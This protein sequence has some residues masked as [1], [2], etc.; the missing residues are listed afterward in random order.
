MEYMDKSV[1]DLT[2]E[3]MKSITFQ[4]VPQFYWKYDW[5]YNSFMV[6]PVA[7]LN[8]TDNLMKMY[9]MLG[10]V[11]EWV[12]DDWSE[13]IS[14]AINGTQ[15]KPAVNP[16]VYNS[17]NKKVIRGG[18]FNQLVR[19]SI[20]STREGLET[21]K[22]MSSGSD[23]ANVG[24]RPSLQWFDGYNRGQGYGRYCVIDLKPSL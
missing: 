22:C 20:A 24:F 6:H 9:D 2:V 8:A 12:R 13:S 5:R 15:D 3:D 1:H 16:M 19:K 21:N 4:V 18:A 10:N 7:K 17:S 11:W 14:E 23:Q